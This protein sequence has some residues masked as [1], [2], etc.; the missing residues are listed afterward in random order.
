[1]KNEK[2]ITL[3]NKI[4]KGWQILKKEGYKEFTRR[5]FYFLKQGPLRIFELICYPYAI[6]KIRSFKSNNSEEIFDFAYNFCLGI[7]RPMQI[8]DEFLDFIKIVKNINP[9]IVLE[10]GTARGGT[11]FLFAKNFSEDASIITVDQ[12]GWPLSGGYPFWEMW[13]LETFK[14]RNQNIYIIRSD[15]QKIETVKKIDS[16]LQG[17]KLDLLFIDGDHSYE[18]VRKDFELYSTLVKNGGIIAFHDC[19]LDRDEYGNG[20][21]KKFWD[22]IKKNY[23]FKEI[24]KDK[25]KKEFGIGVIFFNHTN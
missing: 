24:I 13:L 12:P 25:N 2:K 16:I 15:S 4:R 1:M 9:K 11:L 19:L 10:I 23:S 18:G 20:G 3:L 22:E 21:V 14:K 17:E 5:F 6:Y 8:K 7:I